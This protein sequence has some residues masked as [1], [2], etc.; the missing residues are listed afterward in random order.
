MMGQGSFA[1]YIDGQQVGTGTGPKSYI[2]KYFIKCGRHN[3]TAVVT[4][5][6]PSP[7]LYAVDQ[8]QSNCNNCGSTGFWHDQSCSCKCINSKADCPC[9]SPKQWVD[10]PT[11]GCRCPPK[12]F[13][14]EPVGIIDLELKKPL[15]C[16]PPRYYDEL[17]CSCICHFQL[18]GPKQSFNQKTCRCETISI[19]ADN[20]LFT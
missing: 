4:S 1:L 7:I 12:I 19:T 8:D 20:N 11:C 6:G 17:T 2:F 10:Y 14:S 15:P 13:T 3:L 18:C 16:S 5:K 9:V